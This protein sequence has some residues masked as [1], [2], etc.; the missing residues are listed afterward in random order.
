VFVSKDVTPFSRSQDESLSERCKSAGIDFYSCDDIMLHAPEINVM[1]D[2][3]PYTV[4]TPYCKS[5]IQLPVCQP[6]PFRFDNLAAISSNVLPQT[7]TTDLISVLNLAHIPN[8]TVRGGK[9]AALATLSQIGKHINYE[10][11]RERPDQYGTTRL[12]AYLKF[13]CVS[14]R[15]VWYAAHD[16]L[17]SAHP[18]SRQLCWRDFYHQIAWHF[19]RVF[20]PHSRKN[21]PKLNGIIKSA[22]FNAWCLELTGFPLADAGMREIIKTGL[23]HNRVRMVVASFFTKDLHIDW[24]DGERYFAQHLVDYDPAVNNSNGPR[25]QDAMLKRT[26]RYLTSWLQQKNSILR[27]LIS[28][29][30]YPSFTN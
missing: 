24:R 10:D 1:K 15:E 12:S 14:P 28:I 25:Q 7:R 20:A 17:G 11:I 30:G 8:L 29:V 6:I 26:S 27:L 18:L 16:S 13:G 21:M 3:A 5:A 9:T 22:A 19:P 2:G 23:M 4:F